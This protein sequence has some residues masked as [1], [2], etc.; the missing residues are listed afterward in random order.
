[1][2]VLPL[3]TQARL[4]EVLDY[5]EDTG[6]FR[7]KKK[8]SK[9]SNVKIGQVAG[10]KE[11]Y[12]IIKIE[13]INYKAHRLA[14]MYVTGEDPG[15]LDID[16]DDKNKHN[17]AFSNLRKATRG[18][19]KSNTNSYKNNKVGIKGVRKKGN[20]YKAQIS[21]NGKSHYLGS[22]KTPEAAHKAYC[23]AADKYHGEFANYG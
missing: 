12:I 9:N 18:Q 13:K 8:T 16:H 4:K 14:Y 23:E 7:W 21:K 10:T 20:R 2:K 5:N 15:E 1:M 19:N 6:V 17:N 11:L 22:Y 3:P